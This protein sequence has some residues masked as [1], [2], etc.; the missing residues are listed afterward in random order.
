MSAAPKEAALMSHL[1]NKAMRAFMDLDGAEG[2]ETESTLG[3]CL[4]IAG[5]LFCCGVV[6]QAL[7]QGFLG[8]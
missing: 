5:G 8:L 3:A 6:K 2:T 1:K 7:R 4:R